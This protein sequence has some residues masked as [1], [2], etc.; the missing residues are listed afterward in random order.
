MAQDLTNKNLQNAK[1]VNQDLQAA[2]FS[3]SDLRGADFT[4]ANLTNADFVQVRTGIPPLQAAGIFIA[5]LIVSLTSGYVAMLAGHTMQQMI[6]SG[7]PKIRIAGYLT[8]VMSVI[9]LLFS[10][11]K[12][13]GKAIQNLV[14][15]ACTVAIIIGVIS[16][17]TGAGTG[18][19]ML[20]LVLAIL[21]LALMFIVGTV[22]RA[23]A[24]TLSS[25]I[26]FL[27]VALGGGMF[28]RSVGGGLGTVLMALACVQISKRALSGV[29]GFEALRKIAF[30]ITSRFGT[31]FRKTKLTNANF[32]GT[33]IRNCDFTDADLSLVNWENSK[34]INCLIIETEN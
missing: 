16:Y 2:R 15:P 11:L 17:L 14:I 33:K 19:G 29:K 25:T 24:G 5:A 20:F 10:Y 22:A 27:I 30:A 3:G 32:S 8:I 31:S 21:L 7:D 18:R 9:F 34:K 28:G 6:A 26:L 13:V 23:A 12:G 1:F 4:G